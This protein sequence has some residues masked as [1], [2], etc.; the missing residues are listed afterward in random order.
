MTRR[1]S[2]D[3]YDSANLDDYEPMQSGRSDKGAGSVARLRGG[4]KLTFGVPLSCGGCWCGGK[5]GHD[6]PGKDQGAA[7]PRPDKETT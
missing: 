3:D 4:P 6:W 7:H 5:N 1:P 2:L